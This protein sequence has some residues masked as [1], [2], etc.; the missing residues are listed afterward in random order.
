[1]SNKVELSKKVLILDIE[2]SK[3]IYYSFPSFRPVKLNLKDKIQGQFIISAAWRW[4]G[5]EEIKLVS[6]LDDKR[7]FKRD[8]SDD[9][10]VVN[11]LCEV[12]KEA[13]ILVGHNSDGFDVKHLSFM[14]YKHD[15][16]PLPHLNSIDTLKQARR[17]FK[18][19]S[20]S[21]DEIAKIRQ[22]THKTD[23]P[24]KNQVWNDASSGCPIAIQTIADY[25][26]D[27]IDVQTEMFDDM[28]PWMINHPVLHLLEG[29]AS[30]GMVCGACG[31]VEDLQ[32]RGFAYNKQRTT[33]YQRFVCNTCNHW[34]V[35]KSIN[36]LS[37]KYIKAQNIVNKT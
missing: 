11:E 35:D 3:A 5:E 29:E 4:W 2:L 14:A 20:L 36:M 30:K 32:K 31:E 24:N 25:N 7:R 9:Y 21:M 34:G 26:I 17:R 12:V 10:H 37:K 8:F 13:D 1:M 19:D 18:N 15:L 28:L 6:V 33:K 16:P 23:V 27:D 22:L